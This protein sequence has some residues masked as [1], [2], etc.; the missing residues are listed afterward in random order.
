MS[1]LFDLTY[2][3]GKVTLYLERA[4]FRAAHLAPA[5]KVGAEIMYASTMANFEEEHDPNGNPWVPLSPYT[6]AMKEALGRINKTLQSTGIMKS[7]TSTRV[8]STGFI[9]GNYDKKAR[10]HQLGIDTPMRKFVG[11]GPQDLIDLKA[12]YRFF[13]VKGY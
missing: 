9:I 2:S 6:R 5:H 11:V 13:I 3:D 12:N 4:A 7:R 10:K 8:E 1:D